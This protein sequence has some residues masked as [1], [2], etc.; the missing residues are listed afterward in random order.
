M[1]LKILSRLGSV[2]LF[3][4]SKVEDEAGGSMAETRQYQVF[5]TDF[6]RMNQPRYTYCYPVL[7]CECS[8]GFTAK[9]QGIEF[10]N[11]L[12]LLVDFL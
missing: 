11:P 2:L 1:C 6:L 8:I 12:Y 5:F 9:T 3:I 10:E 4:G 7:S